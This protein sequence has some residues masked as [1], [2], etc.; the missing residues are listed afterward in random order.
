[1][2]EVESFYTKVG[3]IA[4]EKGVTVHIISI[5][6]EECNIHSLSKISEITGG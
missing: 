4:K 6:G 5:I 3:E 1:M 2:N